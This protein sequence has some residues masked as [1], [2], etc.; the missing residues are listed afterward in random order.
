MRK[1]P[2]PVLIRFSFLFSKII[3]LFML[4]NKYECPVCGKKLRKLLPYGIKGRSNALCPNCLSLERHRLLWLFL[5]NKTGFFNEPLKMMHIAPEQPF[6]KRFRNMKNLIY[7]TADLESPLADIKFDIQNIPL[8]DNTYD[9]VMCNHVMEHI[10]DDLKAMKEVYRILKPGGCAFLQV[11]LDTSLN[12][13]YEDKSIT[14][15]LERE[16]H[17]LQKDHVRLYGID[18]G[19][20]LREAGF[21]VQELEYVKELPEDLVKK[22]ALSVNEIIYFSEKK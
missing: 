20:K 3:T 6:I 4:G 5:K 1:V 18:Y 17:F 11:P 16:K 8:A 14:D 13:T 12:K 21:S 22:Y 10:D 15:P 19:K 9:I 7:T 2:R